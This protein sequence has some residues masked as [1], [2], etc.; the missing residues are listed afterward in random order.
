MRHYATVL[1]R[2]GRWIMLGAIVGL[3]AGIASTFL[4]TKAAPT[5]TYFKAT[6][7]LAEGTAPG[8]STPQ[9]GSGNTGYS[10]NQAVLLI[11]SQALLMKVAGATHL[12]TNQVASQLTASVRQNVNAIDVTAIGTDA[13]TTVK[14]ADTAAETLRSMAQDQAGNSAEMQREQLQAQLD[15]R[16]QQRQQLLTQAAQNPP[17]RADLETQINQAT[18]DITNLTQQIQALPAGSGFVLSVLQPATPTQIN[19]HGY[20]Y[21][22]QQNVNARNQ[23][24]NPSTNSSAAPDF[25]ET[26][27]STAAGISKS[28]R[29]LL[30]TVAGLV[31]GLISAFGIEAWDDR[32]RRRDQVESLT[33]LGILTEI[34]RLSREQTRDHH[35]AVVD[36]PVGIPAERYRS[37]RTAINFAFGDLTDVD[38][39]TTPVL[40]VTS[41]G[42]AEGK[43]T[44]VSNLAAAFADD[45]RRVL[46]IDGDFRRP[47]VRRYLGP[48]PNLI[49]PEEP[50]E[51]RI[52]GVWFLPGPRDVPTPEFAAEELI[53]TTGT[54]R[55]EFDLVI[56]DTPPI[57]TTND[58]VEL[59][60]SASA[61]LLVLRA[62]QTRTKAAARVA[63]L[64][65]N[66]RAH[67]VGVLFNG[68][69]RTELSEYYGS[70]FGYGY[71]YLGQS[72][73]KT[74]STDAE[75]SA[76]TPDL[77]DEP[78]EPEAGSPSNGGQSVPAHQS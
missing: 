76:S 24:V 72:A 13:T 57:L 48:V 30:G 12:S 1:R 29:V 47:A 23:L 14:L 3:I 54:W 38:P 70:S 58:A 27:L 8:S 35:V 66:Y 44:A 46:V 64:L 6:N 11:Q 32:V 59:L 28:L 31:L 74:A 7:T 55:N 49:A 4:A 20:N 5:A 62:G 2:R 50:A 69:D 73:K 42:P 34:P 37:A 77:G 17:N 41:P 43:T 16:T 61:V 19:A 45:G 63:E 36:E 53:R 39:G 15:A 26:D 78:S 67:V 75:A 71:G 10:L 52:E 40:M 25:D 21:R 22:Y 60:P 51:T 65:E 56:L 9:S 33:K 18:S 68:C